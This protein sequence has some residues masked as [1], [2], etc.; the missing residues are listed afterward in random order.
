M[1]TLDH[2]MLDAHYEDDTDTLSELSLL[3]SSDFTS[4]E[5]DNSTATPAPST[6]PPTELEL[7]PAL[8]VTLSSTSSPSSSSHTIWHQHPSSRHSWIWQYSNTILIGNEN[9][10][11][12]KLCRNNPKKYV[13]GSTKHPIDHLKLSHRMTAK[14]LLDPNAA[15][16]TSLICQAFG[17]NT[18]KLH[19]NSDIFK[20]L[21][22]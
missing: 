3:E 5:F 13:E 2:A 18:P 17:T 22:V 14:G 20:Q 19:F 4:F 9:Y 7:I 6:I 11:E 10:W 1:A 21:M 16:G 15:N 12:C 8:D